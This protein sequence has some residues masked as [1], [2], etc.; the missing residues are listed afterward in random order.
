MSKRAAIDVAFF[1]LDGL[2]LLGYS[3]DIGDAR[4]ALTEDAAPLGA[5]G[6]WPLPTPTGA[7][8]AE[9]TQAGWF[10]DATNGLHHALNEQQGTSRVLMYG[11]SGN[12]VGQP[13]QGAAGVYGQKYSRVIA[14]NA[15]HKANASYQI[16]G[17]AEDGVIL[18]ALGAET[19]DGNTEG[20]SSVDRNA[21]T[22]VPTVVIATSSVA[23]PTVI[24]CSTPHGLVTGDKVMIAGHTGSTP[25]IDGERV[26][27]VV[28]ATTFTVPLNVTVGGTGGT[29]K[30]LSTQEGGA[31]YVACS[32]LTLGGYTNLA[33]KVRHSQDDATYVDLVSFAALTATGAERKTV[34]GTVYRHLAA[35]WAF[36]G[37]GGAHTATF[38][39]GFARGL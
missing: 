11:F 36:T 37:S 13:F 24:T 22:T 8:R 21:E 14:R 4:E 10:D 29:V 30:R 33:V 19:G 6:V 9:F 26:A 18:H 28:S 17:A 3:A 20:A 16:S 7:K 38:V 27:T 35:S 32:A 23:N 39:V 31:G 2:S 15:L 25:A 5:D 1:L 12:T 34:A